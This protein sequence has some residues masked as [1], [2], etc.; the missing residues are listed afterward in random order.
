MARFRCVCGETI[1]TSG[2]IPN[3]IE[4]NL[5][6]AFDFEAFTGLV[7]A[8]DVYQASR[9]LYRCPKSDHLWVFWRGMD[10]NPRLYAPMALPVGWPPEDDDH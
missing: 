1:R 4:W 3:P 7:Q 5:L 2:E 10:K 9:Y 6:S 8:E